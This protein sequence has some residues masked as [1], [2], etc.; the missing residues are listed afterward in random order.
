MNGE[1]GMTA[2]RFSIG[3][4]LGT[5]S[6]SLSY[7][8]ALSPSR[9][10]TLPLLQWETET[11]TVEKP[12][13]PS[14]CCHLD[15]S[16]KKRNDFVLPFETE[17]PPP[18]WVVG[19]F[20]QRQ[21][22]QHPGQV[23]HS[24]KSWLAHGGL[25]RRN[26]ILPWHSET[27]LGAHRLS[28]VEVSVRYLAH[29]RKAWNATHPDTPMET[30][31]ITITVPASFD[32][33]A[34][35]LTL[36]AAEKAGF[37]PALI[38]LVEEPLAAFYHWLWIQGTSGLE[39]TWHTLV[40][41]SEGE[42]S[43]KTILICD[44]GGGTSDFSLF[45]FYRD[46]HQLFRLERTAVSEHLLLGGDNMDLQVAS[47]LASDRN[48]LTAL[49]WAFL[50]NQARELKEKAFQ[51]EGE[52]NEHLFVS[53]PP[54]GGDLFGTVT[55]LSLSTE[56]IRTAL[57]EGFFPFCEATDRPHPHP[58]G[59]RQLGLPY[60]YDSAITRHIAGFL[61]SK[62]VDAVLFAGGSL[63]PEML[64]QRIVSVLTRWQ[65]HRAPLQLCNT[66]MTLSVSKGA[67]CWQRVSDATSS[68][69]MKSG[70][71]RNLYIAVEANGEKKG[72]CI[73][74][75]GYEGELPI[76]V[77]L[78]GLQARLHQDV[79]LHL[80]ASR[81]RN[82]DRVGMCVP[83]DPLIRQPV[84]LVT[85]FTHS[86]KKNPHMD[87][88][89]EVRLQPN[90]IL[91]LACLEK[92]QGENPTR[93]PLQFQV[94]ETHFIEDPLE[95]TSSPEAPCP[96]SQAG[97]QSFAALL[98]KTF[99]S[100]QQRGLPSSG[101]KF[102]SQLN[103]KG[104]PS[105]TQWPLSSL[106]EL[107]D[108]TLS[109][110]GKRTQSLQHEACWYGLVG[111]L[112]RP[113]FG[114]PQDSMRMEQV[115]KRCFPSPLPISTPRESA[116]A[117]W[118]LWR[119]ISGGLTEAQQEQW[120]N[121]IWP[122]LRQKEASAEMIKFAGSLERLEM[123]KKIQLGN[124]LVDQILL[125]PVSLDARAWSLARLASRIYLYGDA[126]HLIP[127]FYVESWISRLLSM[128]TASPKYRCLVPFFFWSARKILDREFSIEE[129]LRQEVI[130]KME[131]ESPNHPLMES[132]F[133]SQ[134]ITADLQSQVY[135][136]P[137]PLGLHIR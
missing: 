64:Q 31:S 134:P 79:H 74:E 4:D 122:L 107:A 105:A 24:A 90:G 57:L 27:L 43:P 114:A 12:L 124:Y 54:K 52:E 35:G 72:L 68:L 76:S 47:L 94:G 106:R 85:R 21:A 50:Y 16:L 20:A 5:T 7:L 40:K 58:T 75:K 123:N 39:A 28:P 97:I 80:Y 110:V 84:P 96:L 78:P 83:L 87:I 63:V 113:G 66:E 11:T 32:E 104:E 61:Q 23:I 132:L 2:T 120:F 130:R 102:L 37:S 14:F 103:K 51:S 62:P 15:K 88:A 13:L 126:S 45:S 29:I 108:I 101:V 135:G 125:T 30:Q 3:I 9:V 137:L 17:D 98:D 49:Q 115:W 81:E 89:L 129:D 38:R 22:L 59:L 109:F 33:M 121:R 41:R 119:R 73:V 86:N 92:T 93:W 127:A 55:T 65:S 118:I 131:K 6:C 82:E 136:E 70:Y 10:E 128:P 111:Y 48:S 34:C 67:A 1:E 99:D 26:P 60:A 71:P 133:V 100:A 42:T 69:V 117:G 53:L 56:E 116:E 77:S 91:E 44:V 25:E 18:T 95:E 8:D 36:E 19:R 112:L 46:T